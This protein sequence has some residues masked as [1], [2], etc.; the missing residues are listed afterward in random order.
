MTT[1]PAPTTTGPSTPGPSTNGSAVD[2]LLAAFEGGHGA[3]VGDLYAADAVLDATVPGWR[4]R[5][6]G[7]AAIADVYSRWFA[8]SGRF[9]E[10]DR[11]PTPDGEVVTYLLAWEERGIPHAARHGHV[12][13]VDPTTGRITSD[14][15]FCGGRWDAARLAEME[16]A[17]HAV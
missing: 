2:R 3:A 1:T 15:V 4:F 8:D 12:L 14:V 10:I 7:P 16:V 6:R 5:A 11:Q 17:D 9:E 13:S